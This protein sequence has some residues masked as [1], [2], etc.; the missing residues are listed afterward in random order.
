M[1][2]AT[3]LAH[4]GGMQLA[5]HGPGSIGTL[6]LIAG[7][8]VSFSIG[9]AFMKAS[10]GFSRPLP[11]AVVAALFLAGAVLLS[12]AV[13]V[14]SMSSAIVIGLGIEAV[15]TVLIGV[16]VLGDSVRAAHLL[17]MMLIVAGVGVL[18]VL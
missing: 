2:R 9:A 11:S 14:D 10:H 16:V 18:R 8:S 13:M 7:G 5:V 1:R 15:V 3:R 4:D 12:R 17:G 6:L